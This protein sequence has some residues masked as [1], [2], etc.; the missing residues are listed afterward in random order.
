MT[1]ANYSDMGNQ[2]AITPFADRQSIQYLPHVLSAVL[3]KLFKQNAFLSP[4][5]QTTCQITLKTKFKG[6]KFQDRPGSVYIY[7][8]I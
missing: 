8:P 1:K 4:F 3:Y 5:L 6:G 7:H 2:F